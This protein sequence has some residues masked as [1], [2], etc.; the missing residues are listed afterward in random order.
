MFRKFMKRK[1][2]NFSIEQ[3]KMVF[4]EINSKNA[5]LN[6][7]LEPFAEKFYNMDNTNGGFQGAP[8]FLSLRFDAIFYF[9]L[10]IKKKL[11]RGN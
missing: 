2:N 5:V 10:K 9:F 1:K 6:Q 11:L 4:N 8:K 7:D 3:M